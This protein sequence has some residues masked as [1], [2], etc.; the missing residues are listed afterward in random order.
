MTAEFE[1]VIN[2]TIDRVITGTIEDIKADNIH[3]IDP[4]SIYS[5]TESVLYNLPY[6]KEAVL[7]RREQIR[8]IEKYGVPMASKS[9]TVF[10]RNSGY[11]NTANDYE[12]KENKLE[13]LRG[14]IKE[15]EK[16]IAQ[17]EAAVDIVRDDPHFP[18]IKMRYF[19]KKT[20][21]QIAECLN[22]DE[23]TVKRH[24]NKMLESIRFALFRD[25]ILED[26]LHWLI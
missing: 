13:Q 5:K 4:K 23:S 11:V 24:K 18:I 17:I 12:R 10:T 16:R 26:M 19:E 8:E 6:L 1:K 15:L 22:C 14:L 7:N 21:V 20:Y 25:T 9:F 3:A 2:A